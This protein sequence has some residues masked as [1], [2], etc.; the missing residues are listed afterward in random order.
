MKVCPILKAGILGQ[1]CMVPSNLAVC[2]GNECE[3]Y[4]RGCPA[5]RVDAETMKR[6]EKNRKG[7]LDVKGTE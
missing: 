5:H 3:W 4:E 2:M 6:I 7:G 1:F